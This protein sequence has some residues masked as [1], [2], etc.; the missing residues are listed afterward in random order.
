MTVTYDPVAMARELQWLKDNPDFNERPATIAEFLGDRY[1]NIEARVRPGVREALVEIFGTEID[2]YRISKKRRAIFTGAIGI[3]KTTLASIGLPYMVHWILCLK[4]PQGY[5]GLLPGSRIAFMQMS[6]SEQQAREVIFGDIFARIQHSP[7]F[8][9]NAPYDEKYTKQIRFPNKDIWIIPGD[10]SENTFEG[11]NILGGILDEMD[12][13]K[14]TKEKDYA[15]LGYD[16]I[17]GRIFSRFEDRGLLI[18]I[19]Q[20]KKANGFAAKKYNEFRNDPDAWTC[21][22]T[23]WESLGWHRYL[24]E[25]GTRNSFYY[26]F[27][28]RAVIPKIVGQMLDPDRIKTLLEIPQMFWSNF[29]NNPEKSLRDLAGIPPAVSD[30]FISLVD[31]IELCRDRWVERYAQCP[32]P[33]GTNPILIEFEDW[34]R[35][36][37]A[38]K[39]AIHIDFAYSANGDALGLAMGHIAGLVKSEED[40]MQPLIVI[41]FLARLK[42]APGT[43][44][45]LADVRK[46]I[47][48]LRDN[49][50][51]RIARVTMDGFQSVETRQQLRKKRFS[52]DE[53]SVDK[54][55]QPYE[56][57]REAIYE[58]RL[59][60]P[61]FITY[62]NKGDAETI[63]IV[64][65]ELMELT[66]DGR[67]VDHPIDGSKDVADAMAGVV[68]TLVGNRS[69]RRGVASS[70]DEHRTPVNNGMYA[71]GASDGLSSLVD[72][73][74][75]I[76]SGGQQAPS[77]HDQS[78]DRWGMQIPR[79][80]R[81]R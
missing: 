24:N 58:E 48:H 67:K 44:I 10:S 23:L 53:L 6:T 63:E 22:M 1:L 40:E 20:M 69:Y 75:R 43:E 41:D 76:N 31:K 32:S 62:L 79:H 28:R 25:D 42:A 74:R 52:V 65:K 13:H 36:L 57:L 3:G 50:K 12:S 30:P 49:L 38:R 14:Q 39:R 81:P 70:L 51:F 71:Q 77:L 27:K 64:I 55:T 8:M 33:V 7:W 21:R 19:G 72:A 47:Y 59:E 46:V 78:L 34:F 11:Y 18:L 80:L 9:E 61:P 66:S 2:P 37:D 16:T 5:F 26:D 54:D 60:F 56:D 4:D 35:A 73:V 45:M 29:T 17:H 15:D 68:S